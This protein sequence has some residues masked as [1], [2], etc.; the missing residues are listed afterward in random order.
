MTQL[1]DIRAQVQE[2]LDRAQA[3]SAYFEQLKNDAQAAGFWMPPEVD[4]RGV[5]IRVRNVHSTLRQ[6]GWKLHVSAS[7]LTAP[8][9]LS[10]SLSVLLADSAS[11]KVAASPRVLA[12]LNQGESGLSQ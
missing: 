11:F 7:G 10:T 12:Q 6:Q 9:V 3:D 4:D 1:D 8:D 5:W 2:V